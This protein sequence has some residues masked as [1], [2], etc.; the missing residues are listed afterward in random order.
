MKYS[1]VIPAII[2]QN[3]NAV[4]QAAS[5]LRFS[6]ELHLDIVD[7]VFVPAISWP[8]EP[9]GEPQSVKSVLDNYTL[10]VDLMTAEPIIA[11]TKWVA[12]GADMLVFHVETLVLDIFK[13]FTEKTPVSV[14]VSCSGETKIETLLAY[15]EFADYVQLMGIY[16]I[17]SQGQ[18][19]DE[20]VFDKIKT[21]KSK[22][23]DMMVS[24]D[25]SVN[26]DTILS[27]KKAGADRF[28]VGSAIVKQDNP[29]VAHNALLSL[30]NE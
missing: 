24:V 10:E 15:A 12:A 8:Y 6:R 21:V 2:P 25:G 17:G 30:I 9:T 18:P 3:Q 29:E 27:L 14:G 20:A 19:F 13:K 4:L 11:A 16:Q 1:Q 22:F 5:D 26:P 28:I 23:P 7:G